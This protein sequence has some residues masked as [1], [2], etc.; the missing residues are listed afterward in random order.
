RGMLTG[1]T[2]G[3]TGLGGTSGNT[4]GSQLNQTSG[5]TPAS[6]SSTTVG[7]NTMGLNTSPGLA[8]GG[9]QNNAMSFSAGHATVMADPTTNTLIIAAPEPMYRSLRE[10]I[11][12]L[13]VRRAQIFVESLIVEVTTDT[14][15][16]FGIQWLTGLGN[17]GR[18]IIGGTSFGGAGSNILTTAANL[19]SVGAGLSI[20]IADGTVN[21]P[22][23]GDV[24]NLGVLA[25]ALENQ[26]GGNI[27]STPNLLTLDNEEASI[28]IGQ[29]VPFITGQ[30]AQTSN[31][32]T[33]SPFQTIERKDVGLTLKV[34]PQVSEGGTV[35]MTIYQEVSSVDNTQI[36]AAGIITNKRAIESNVLV[37]DGQIVVI[38]GLVQD[39]VTG[40]EQK[41]PFLGDI[42]YLGALFR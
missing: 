1:Q 15:S 25:R 40:G 33:V 37:D 13:D 5:L 30:Y 19:G 20:G 27:L 14:A 12:L 10:V 17:S 22:G 7:G 4:F 6:S 16:E 21:V 23:V 39:T 11:D 24:T 28:I 42:P 32:S 9:A 31:T 3:G 41:V 38:G 18:S 2:S 34:K 36:N 26:S 35:K 29:N 8:G